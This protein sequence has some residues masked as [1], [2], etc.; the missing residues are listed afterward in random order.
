MRVLVTGA[1]G[2]L[3]SLVRAALESEK[4]IV[5]PTDVVAGCEILDIRDTN[6]VFDVI[7]RTRPEMVIHCAAMT[8]VDGC[9]RDPDS[10][11]KINAVGTW[12]LACACAQIDC[13]IAYVGTDYVFNGEK[14]SPYTEFD[15][16]DPISHYGG[17]KL[18][19]ENAVREICR[20][21]YVVRTSWIF[22][23]HGKNFAKSI[24]GAAE[25]RDELKVVADQYGSPT[26]AKDLAGF[27]ASLVGSPLYGVYHFTNAGHCSWYDFAKKILETAGKTNV[28]VVPINSDEWPTPTRR[29]KF[30]VLRHYRMELLGRDKVRPWEDAVAEFVNEWTIAKQ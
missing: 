21:H 4:H 28:N 3:G 6:L 13:A 2:M 1:C 27:L 23:P 24:L 11:Y 7:N 14:G 18:A 5:I 8:D 25:T 12:N 19:G 10:A 30:S 17:S 16:T 29:P 26:Y 9:E 15:A 20:K 22:A